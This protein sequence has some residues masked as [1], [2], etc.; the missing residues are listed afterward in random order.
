M[1]DA[2]ALTR[3]TTLDE[4]TSLRCVL[5]LRDATC[6]VIGAIVGVG[7]FFNP[8]DVAAISGSTA[9]S[10]LA[11]GIGGVIAL[12]GAITFAELGRLRPVAGG[13]YHILR[14]A[15]G[16]PAAFLCVFC[17]VTAIQTGGV[18]I[19]SIVCAQNLGVALHGTAP[20]NTWTLA[21]ATVLTWLLVGANVVGVRA[22]AGLQNTAVLL[23][24]IAIAAIVALAAM[25]PPGVAAVHAAGEARPLAFPALFAGVTLTLFAYGG[26]Q[27][28]LWMA[29][30]VRDA[31]R[32]VPRA[33]LLGV[34]IV[35]AVYLAV[36][37]AYFRML[38]YDG[39]R[40]AQA[41]AAD[42]ISVPAGGLGRRIAAAVVAVSAFG[43]L[44]AQFLAGP[45]LTWALARDGSFFAPFARLS[46]RSATPVAAIL[47]LGALATTMTLGLGLARTDLF[48]TGIV[49]I[50]TAFFALTALALPIL[51]RRE[52]G[53]GL[54]WRSAIA[55]AFVTLELLAIVG[56]VL[57]KDVRVVAL[58][59]L[60]WI[61]AAA[62]TWGLFFARRQP[63]NR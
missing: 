38:G 33:I 49:V 59:G 56:S 46:A 5:G 6:I 17:N 41:L 24:L 27:Q 61:A 3:E 58:T 43:V 18:A 39:V 13:Q 63:K 14:D 4:P 22:G 44:N 28:G 12:L 16:R 19:I 54:A 26:W 35:V 15:F 29:G 31:G 48:T 30:E 21:V 25:L 42:A 10:L 50:D 51:L 47:L 34:T 55:L 7:I 45:R 20:G 1:S 8:R 32:T 2:P 37:W 23:K 36:N 62:L 60:G 53:R 40:N 9:A 52:G 57:Q 11:W